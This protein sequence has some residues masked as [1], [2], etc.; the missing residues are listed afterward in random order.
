MGIGI[1]KRKYGI[2]VILS[3]YHDLC[4]EEVGVTYQ[5]RHGRHVVAQSLADSDWYPFALWV[6][7]DCMD[8]LLDHGQLSAH[9]MITDTVL[10]KGQH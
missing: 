2:K 1:G 8:G 3:I 10:V 7:A 6:L 5:V 4:I 9:D